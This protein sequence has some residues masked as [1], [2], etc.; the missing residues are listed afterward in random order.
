MPFF[1]KPR[2]GVPRNMNKGAVML[3]YEAL[4][5]CILDKRKQN[6]LQSVVVVLGILPASRKPKPR[7]PLL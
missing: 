2:F 5:E 7:L 6:V 3:E 4:F 1:R